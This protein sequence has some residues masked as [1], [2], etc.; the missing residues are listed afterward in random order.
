MLV[1][2]QCCAAH[3]NSSALGSD[4]S[5]LVRET[6]IPCPLFEAHRWRSTLPTHTRLP[7]DLQ[8][9]QSADLGL[10]YFI[11]SSSGR[12]NHREFHQEPQT[13]LTRPQ[14]C[15]RPSL[16]PPAHL[17]LLKFCLVNSN[18]VHALQF[19]FPFLWEMTRKLY[20]EL[21][22][23]TARSCQIHHF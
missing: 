11:W 21:Q 16:L 14:P 13:C 1:W 19:I 20:D 12:S 22:K 5:W 23:N 6:W 7:R 4:T 15:F 18:E 3:C 8:Q 9:N 2:A 10:H 17:H